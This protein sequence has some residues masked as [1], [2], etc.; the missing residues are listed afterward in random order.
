MMPGGCFRQTTGSPA[1]S[2]ERFAIV[3][4]VQAGIFFYDRFPVIAKILSDIRQ[5]R[6]MKL[7]GLAM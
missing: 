3:P 7:F 5:E 2:S 6:S 4:E 1:F